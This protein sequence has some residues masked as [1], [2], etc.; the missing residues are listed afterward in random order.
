MIIIKSYINTTGESH[1]SDESTRRTDTNGQE[2]RF[3]AQEK[4][5]AR[6]IETQRGERPTC[7]SAQG[8]AENAAE[9]GQNL[10]SWQCIDLIF[11][12]LKYNMYLTFVKI[13]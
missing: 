13:S 4:T 2:T 12:F 9:I 6:K 3:A 1:F 10:Q 8:Q 7:Q 11:D 5:G